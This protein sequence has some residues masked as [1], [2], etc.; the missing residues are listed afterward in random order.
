MTRLSPAMRELV[1]RGAGLTLSVAGAIGLLWLFV[2]QP[3]N[4][5]ELTGGVT[6]SV[7]AYRIDQAEFD[8]ARQFFAQDKFVEARAAFLRAD[9]ASRD[10]AT[11]FYVAYS[12]Y[13]QGWGRLYSDDALFRQGLDAVNRALA[14]AP[15]GT[16]RVD[17]PQL[18]MRT[19]D[20]LKAELEQGLRRDASDFNPLRVLRTRR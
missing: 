3:T 8:Q 2:Q 13:R 20:E 16:L 17:D 4:L 6:A 9:P 5:E 15:G 10:A 19:A 1:V 12:Y 18:D 14:I 11:Q 7:G